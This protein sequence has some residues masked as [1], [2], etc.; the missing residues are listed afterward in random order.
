[1]GFWG[2]GVLGVWGYGGEAR[3]ADQGYGLGWW[4]DRTSPTFRTF[5]DGAFGAQAWI[6]HDTGYGVYLVV[7]TGGRDGNALKDQLEPVINE[8]L[9]G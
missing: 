9:A 4:I 6:D 3:N 1:M 8:L 7:E 5:N 2:F